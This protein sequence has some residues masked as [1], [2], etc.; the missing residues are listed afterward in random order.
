MTPT[1]EQERIEALLNP[2]YKVIADYPGNELKVGIV[3]TL[4]DG[5]WCDDE[6]EFTSPESYFKQY[7]HLYKPMA[8]WEERE[9]DEM[10]EYLSYISLTLK[11]KFGDD[12]TKTRKYVI[13]NSWHMDNNGKWYFNKNH[14]NKLYLYHSPA[15]KLDYT[16]YIN[17]P[18]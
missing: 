9:V 6:Y 11:D 16:T 18:K 8:W 1:Q 5:M 15:T 4:T 12:E 3:L 14:F 17:Q 2:R 10:P 7:P 13:I